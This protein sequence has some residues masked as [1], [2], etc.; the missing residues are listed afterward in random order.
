MIQNLNWAF[1]F[2]KD[3][4]SG[5][6]SL[7]ANGRNAFLTMS[8][9]S[10]VVYDYENRSQTILQGHCNKIACC[11]VDKSKRWIVTADIG[12]DPIMIVWD[13]ISC[14][15]VKTYNTPHEH[16][17]SAIDISDDAVFIATLS[18]Q[19]PNA[20]ADQQ[21]AIWAWTAEEM[22]PV[23]RQSIDSDEAH[24]SIKFNPQNKSQIVS[25]GPKTVCFW[26]WDEYTL[27]SYTGKVSK[28]DLGNYT[29]HFVSSLFLP[30]TVNALSATSDGYII[31]WEGQSDASTSSAQLMK[32]AAKVLR[33]VDC[34]INLMCT[35]ANDYLVLGCADGAVRFYDFYLRLEAWFEDLAAG[36]VTSVTFADA[37]CPFSAGE[38]GAPGLR[39]WVPDFIVGTVDAFVI[40]VESALFDEVKRED[41]RGIL[42][43]Q[44]MSSYIAAVACHPG[45]PLIAILCSNGTLQLWN[46]ELKLLMCIR[47]FPSDPEN[48][49]IPK[50]SVHATCL[51]FDNT[52][53][54]LAVGFSSGIVKILDSN[55]MGDLISFAPTSDAIVKLKFSQTGNF[56]AGYDSRH[57][58]LLW[59]R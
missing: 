3:K 7:C 11:V 8:S 13:A 14:L 49:N 53:G 33:L 17:V 9:H 23:L 56:L 55:T 51:S 52:G 48:K 31:L 40:G 20:G 41:R 50:G 44:G 42:L 38:A 28:T 6:H 59:A 32:I 1:G 26:H 10:A 2:N 29:G 54:F 12:H 57:H 25:S 35:T 21:I 18:A 39:F 24:T 45:Q 30:G 47:E 34:G 5:I 4:V 22:E 46:Y 58:L 36:A 37:L 19:D 16:G 27:E 43:L 15:P